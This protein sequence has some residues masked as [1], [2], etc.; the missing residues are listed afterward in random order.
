MKDS[1]P[2]AFFF[3]GEQIASFQLIRPLRIREQSEIWFV[4]ERE[5]GK[6]LAVKFLRK[7][8]P[9]IFQFREIAAVLQ[10]NLSPYLIHVLESAETVQGLPYAVMEYAERGTL[11]RRLAGGA[12]LPLAE[13]VRLLRETL[14]ALS[15]LHRRGIVHRD[16]KPENLWRMADGSIRLGDLGLAKL[17]N[18]PEEPGR[19][20][21]TAS[22]LSPEQALDSTRLDGRSDLYSLA[23]VLFEALTGR[24]YRRP[25][26]SF[27][28]AV[29]AVLTDQSAPPLD[30][31][32]QA[33][34]DKLAVLL[35]RMMERTPALRPASADDVLRELNA[36]ELP[37]E[38]GDIRR[39]PHEQEKSREKSS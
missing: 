4:R 23:L 11:R 21:G 26:A 29:K 19:V 22:Y 20:F 13:A 36:M 3:A 39:N 32:R 17:P 9:R 8:H 1:G 38:F 5:S 30:L 2:S 27:T 25:S 15:A 24:R 6:A 14:L 37:E 31:L 33:A 10:E 28:G 18:D 12:V 16:V 35:G 34:T 7:E